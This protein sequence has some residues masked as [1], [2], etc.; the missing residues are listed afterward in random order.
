MKKQNNQKGITLIA[1][2]ITIIVMLILV[3]V[4]VTVALNGGLFNQAEN[5]RGRT[6]NA[7]REENLRDLGYVEIGNQ[8]YASYDKYI[9]GTPIDKEA[10]FQ[11]PT[12]GVWYDTFNDYLA[13]IPSEHQGAYW[14]AASYEAY[15]ESLGYTVLTMDQYNSSF[16]DHNN[17]QPMWSY[18]YT[19][20]ALPYG[21]TGDETSSERFQFNTTVTDVLIPNTMTLIDPGMFYGSSLQSV[22]IPE[23]VK[24]IGDSAFAQ[25]YDLSEVTFA[26]EFTGCTFGENAFYDTKW[27]EDK[28]NDETGQ[29]EVTING[30]IY[31]WAACFV[32]GTKV[33]TPSGLVN[34]ENVK[35]GD[36]II[37]KNNET[38]K[39]EEKDVLKVA[40]HEIKYNTLKIYVSDS[41]IEVTK[42]HRM[43]LKDVGYTEAR[44][45]KVGDILVNVNNVELP[46]EKIEE[47]KNTGIKKVYNFIVED[48]HNYFVG[49]DSILVHNKCFVAGSKVLTLRGL[50]NIEDIKVGDYVITYN[51]ETGRNEVHKVTEV[52]IHEKVQDQVTVAFKDGSKVEMNM[53]H[54]LYTEEGWKSLS[55][56]NGYETLK[57]GD[58]VKAEEGYKEITE[59]KVDLSKEPVDM[60]TINVEGADNFYVNGTLAHDN[61]Y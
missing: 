43:Y 32:E 22:Y 41:E 59:I 8:L 44:N 48:N 35:V 49:I 14:D 15:A 46:I 56:Y 12:T 40:E 58:K 6:L 28:F 38:G 31:S 50:V 20:I 51:E 36:R 27:I 29:F 57:V 3:G 33:L 54:P 13:G 1:L 9:E 18:S 25:C 23:S 37:S 19:K 17:D 55:G 53:Y 26:K 21:V 39:I 60:Y 4:S 61:E 52:F 42:N 24:T 11:D 7:V 10:R 16:W 45:L 34:I 47:V 2:I 30:V 5:A